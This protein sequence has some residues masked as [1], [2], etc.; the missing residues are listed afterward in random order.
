MNTIPQYS[1]GTSYSYLKDSEHES[2][3]IYPNQT[4]LDV[5][6]RAL[7]AEQA[8]AREVA[9]VL[10]VLGILSLAS[11]TTLCFVLLSR[12]QH[13]EIVVRCEIEQPGLLGANHRVICPSFAL[14]SSSPSRGDSK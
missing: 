14:P 8:A 6:L 2:L 5:K 11:I 13:R 1:E 9:F 7:R 4:A 12:P 10:G 3:I